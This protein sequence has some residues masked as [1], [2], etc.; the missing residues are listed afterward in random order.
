M[1]SQVKCFNAE[2]AEIRL[3]HVNKAVSRIIQGGGAR[4]ERRSNGRG[5]FIRTDVLVVRDQNIWELLLPY[6]IFELEKQR[7]K[8]EALPVKEDA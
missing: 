1:T 6:F 4:W 3:V 7:G 8:H 2:T 5:G